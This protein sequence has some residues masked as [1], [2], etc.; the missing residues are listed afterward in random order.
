MTELLNFF[1]FLVYKLPLSVLISEGLI[2][3]T[4]W[5]QPNQ[6]TEL[7]SHQQVVHRQICGSSTIP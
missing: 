7:T 5:P 2:I 1:V 6:P 4:G 3:P